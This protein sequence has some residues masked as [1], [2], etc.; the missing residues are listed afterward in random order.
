[1]AASPGWYDGSNVAITSPLT[2]TG[3]GGTA[4]TAVTF[5]LINNKDGA[6]ATAI[7]NGRLLVM[8]RQAGSSDAFVQSGIDALDRHF[9]ELQTVQGYQK[10]VAA[11][12]WTQVGADAP[13]DG[14]PSSIANDEGVEFQ[15]RVNAPA[16][17]AT[18]DLEVKIVLIDDR[19][20][21]YGMGMSVA[22]E[23]GIYSGIGDEGFSVIVSGADL[24]EDDTGASNDVDYPD[25]VYIVRGKVYTLRAGEITVAASTATYNRYVLI[26]I[27]EDGAIQQTAGTEVLTALTDDDKPALPS[28][29]VLSLA[30]VA[31]DDT[32]TIFDADIENVYSVGLFP[33]TSS[34]LTG[35]I[36]QGPYAF[37]DG[38]LIYKNGSDNVTLTASDVNYIWLLP[39]GS[40]EK[41]LT[42]Y[43]SDGKAL[44][45]Y[46][47]TTD[48]SG[49]T[50]T[51]DRRI[52]S[53]A[54]DRQ[55]VV[56]HWDGEIDTSTYRYAHLHNPREGWLNPIRPMSASLGS[57]GSGTGGSTVWEVD[58]LLAG[59]FTALFG[60]AADGPTI[61][62]NAAATATFD[63]SAVPDTWSIPRFARIRAKHNSIPTGSGG[64]EPNDSTLILEVLL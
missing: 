4:G 61:A 28:T 39:S 45:L 16:D 46:A 7:Q 11:V 6:G 13:Y 9:L 57:Q 50:A 38:S 14:V 43:P 15:I 32:A 49:V 25:F 48:G 44:P 40:I 54:N 3:T 1:M 10:T 62:Y 33:F 36:G 5:K 19:N 55:F 12:G 41:T 37:V 35:T 20:T 60:T 64:V 23:D 31:R 26:Y 18:V 2:I 30:F 56:F 27:D 42:D 52:L 51:E 24:T 8:A 22:G 63:A 21:V 53:G 47:I 58:V 29:G 34:S 17:T 59:T